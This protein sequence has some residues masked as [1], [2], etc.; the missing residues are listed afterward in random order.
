M[1]AIILNVHW[2]KI[3]KL[4]NCTKNI[5][6]SSLTECT[7]EYRNCRFQYE[8]KLQNKKN[9]CI[10]LYISAQETSTTNTEH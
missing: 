7:H 4:R 1:N 5:K 9:E 6:T 10:K 2:K 8:N 3:K